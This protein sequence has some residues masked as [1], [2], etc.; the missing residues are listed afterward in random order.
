M[1][2]LSKCFQPGQKAVASRGQSSF[3]S[4]PGFAARLYKSLTQTQAIQNEHREI[5]SYLVSRKE[6][7]R[8]LDVGTGPGRLLFELYQLNPALELFGLDI[9]ES[10]VELARQQLAGLG[11]DV[12]QGGILHT[13]YEDSF[14]DIVTCTGSFYLW[15]FAKECLEE[16]FRILKPHHSA[17]LFETYS[18]CDRREVRNAIKANLRR[19]SLVRRMLAPYF[20]NKQLRMTYHSDEVAGIIEQTR[21]AHTYAIDRISLGGLPAWLRISLTKEV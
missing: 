19:E 6:C 15:D 13:R 9:S 2:I 11:A 4:L 7:G 5:A 10:M 18:N 21:F 20:L 12:R 17:Y 3:L 14:F 16:V 8:I 1:D